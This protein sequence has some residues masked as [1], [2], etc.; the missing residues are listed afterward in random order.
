MTAALD[1]VIT[2]LVCGR[3]KDTFVCKSFVITTVIK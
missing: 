3:K 1:K 2:Q